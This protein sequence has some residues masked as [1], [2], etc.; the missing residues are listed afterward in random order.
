VNRHGRV[1][2]LAE[3]P[4]QQDTYGEWL[5]WK[6]E[7]HREQTCQDCHMSDHAF[8]GVRRVE[9]L[10]QS[11]RASVTED[12]SGI[13]LW[14]EGV[15]HKLP[16]GDVMRSLTIEVASDVL[17]ED[18][19]EVASFG[20]RLGVQTWPGEAAPRTGLLA[21]S[22]LSPGRSHLIR[23]P[24]PRTA[25]GR[26]WRAWRLVYHLVSP[27]QERDGLVPQEVSRITVVT[28]RF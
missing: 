3:G 27:T 16:T 4:P 26:P 17:F 2:H 25:E 8:G 23:V 14:L 21:N 5:A 18:A 1:D 13:E 19:V 9:A 6:A 11:I 24:L 28:Q 7:T 20:H 12:G 15:G 22:S 10:R